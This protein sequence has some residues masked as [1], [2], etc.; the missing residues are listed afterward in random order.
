MC[1]PWSDFTIAPDGA[2]SLCCVCLE[3]TPR[4]HLHVDPTD[5]VPMDMCKTCAEDKEE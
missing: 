2:G 1:S 3:W 4:E 5:G